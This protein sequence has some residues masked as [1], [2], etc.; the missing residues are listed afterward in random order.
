[1]N[2]AIEGNEAAIYVDP[3]TGRE[4]NVRVRLAEGD[5]RTLEDLRRL[6]I[7]VQGGKVVPLENAQN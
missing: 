4:N 2:T 7:P 1:V 6:P 5:R 3:I